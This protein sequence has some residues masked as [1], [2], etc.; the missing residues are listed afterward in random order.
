[1]TS[2][3]LKHSWL[4]HFPISAFAISMGVFGL[5]LAL[6]AARRKLLRLRMLSRKRLLT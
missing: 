2:L 3:P 4:M 6:R 1:M 5:S